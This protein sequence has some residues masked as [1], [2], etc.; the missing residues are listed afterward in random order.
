MAG[1]HSAAAMPNGP[2]ETRQSQK[3][4]ISCGVIGRQ[5]SRQGSLQQPGFVVSTGS[6]APNVVSMGSMGL[7]ISAPCSSGAV[8]GRQGSRQGSLQQLGLSVSSGLHW[9]I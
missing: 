1:D 4:R 6:A 9:T 8:I 3:P 2:F 7:Q 5:G